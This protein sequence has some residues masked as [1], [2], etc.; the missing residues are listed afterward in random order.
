MSISGRQ[1]KVAANVSLGTQ[2]KSIIDNPKGALLNHKGIL[3]KGLFWGVSS[4]VDINRQVQD[5]GSSL[6]GA[7]AKTLARNAMFALNPTATAIAGVVPMVYAG[8][9]FA[10]THRRQKAE[11][12]LAFDNPSQRL[13]GNYMDTQRAQTMRQAAVQQIQGN[14]LN[15]RSALGGEARIFS[16]RHVT[17]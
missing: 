5:E 15:A 11:Q 10:H 12:L 17:G 7:A 6:S 16:N 8:A 9:E 2:A 13:G 1:A 4:A 14:K 3:G